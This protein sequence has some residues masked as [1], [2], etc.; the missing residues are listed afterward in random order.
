MFRFVTLST[1]P[2]AP[3][4]RTKSARSDMKT[5]AKQ[6]MRWVQN[7]SI[8]RSTGN[9]ALIYRLIFFQNK[10]ETKY[11]S[12][13]R[14]VQVF[15][16]NFLQ[17]EADCFRLQDTQCQTFEETK[18]DKELTV[19]YYLYSI[20]F[21]NFFPWSGVRGQVLRDLR[22]GIRGGL[23]HQAGAEVWGTDHL[24]TETN[25]SWLL[26]CNFKM[27]LLFQFLIRD[28]RPNT[29]PWQ[30]LSA[31]LNMRLCMMNNALQVLFSHQR[32]VPHDID[33]SVVETVYDN[34]CEKVY[35]TVYEV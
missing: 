17:I 12:V 30:R 4:F 8:L 32:L 34:K 22:N 21:Y 7:D 23:H 13:C 11:D 19:E 15:C 26:H 27:I 2:S 20:F 29:T 33:I 9:W 31:R 1:S 10:C 14:D 5:N 18:C 6:N 3:Q 24:E 35:E 16:Q 28:R 25:L